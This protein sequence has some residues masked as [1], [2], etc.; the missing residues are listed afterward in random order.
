MFRFSK[1]VPGEPLDICSA[2]LWIGDTASRAF[3]CHVCQDRPDVAFDVQIEWGDTKVYE[4]LNWMCGSCVV[5]LGSISRNCNGKTLD[6]IVHP[7]RYRVL[8]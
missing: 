8:G 4:S 1:A 5:N 6:Q 3:V 7:S 2:Q